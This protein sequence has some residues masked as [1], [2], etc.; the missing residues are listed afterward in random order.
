M[1][2]SSYTCAY[3]CSHVH[4]LTCYPGIIPRRLPQFSRPPDD[5]EAFGGAVAALSPPDA[6]TAHTAGAGIEYGASVGAPSLNSVASPA[7]ALGA[8]G[9]L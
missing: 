4:T 5:G 7:G 6:T 8:A 2:C 3:T 1:M 9:W